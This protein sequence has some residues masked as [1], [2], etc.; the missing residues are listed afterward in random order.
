MKTTS[1]T[2]KTYSVGGTLLKPCLL[3]LGLAASISSARGQALTATLL[4]DWDVGAIAG[5]NNLDLVT[6][7]FGAHGRVAS[8]ITNATFT[9][10]A[11]YYLTNATPSGKPALFFSNALSRI[12]DSLVNPSLIYQRTNFSV[13]YVF[14]VYTNLPPKINGSENWFTENNIVDGE[15]PGT[16]YDWGTAIRTD[17]QWTF[18]TGGVAGKT[19]DRSTKSF[20]A[21]L[22]D[23]NYHVVVGTWGNGIANVY[24][25]GRPVVTSTFLSADPRRQNNSTDPS[26]TSLDAAGNITFGGVQTDAGSGSRRFRGNLA[27]VQFYSTNLG[28][29]DVS[30]L[31]SQLSTKFGLGV[32]FSSLAIQNFS[33]AAA[34]IAP[35]SS[36]TLNWKVAG[37]GG[38]AHYL[39]YNSIS[40]YG[41][42]G[43]PVD[44]TSN[45]VNGVG[46]YTVS[47]AND[48]LYELVVTNADS[49][50]FSTYAYATV[51]VARTAAS[52]LVDRWVPSGFDG[53]F[54]TWTGANGR[55]ATWNGVVTPPAIYPS[56]ITNATTNGLPA[57]NFQKS[58]M[59]L[60]ASNSLAG[61]LNAFTVAMVVQEDINNPPTANNAIWRSDAGIYDTVSGGGANA[62]E[63]SWG[64]A[65]KQSPT[66]ATEVTYGFRN[67]G[68]SNSLASAPNFD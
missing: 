58:K 28:T 51:A 26:N 12:D 42:D 63:R 53:I 50:Q 3:A 61:G 29:T 25:D 19:D 2:T 41:P 34:T 31:I 39:L 22:L 10:Q 54:N 44:V 8:S 21:S 16:Q 45:T 32:T 43:T 52:S 49:S 20:G 68:F 46:S 57:V 67:P 60:P 1:T 14:N 36:A 40:A 33:P 30:N 37:T 7:W 13:A 65:I 5:A 64:V 62:L 66:L 15:Q 48:T 47:P 17:G 59:L 6:N 18:G 27:E 9:A 35:G 56:L 4:E 23:G 55:V 24:V 38:S 11:P